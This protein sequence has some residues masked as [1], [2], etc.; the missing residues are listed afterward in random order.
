MNRRLVLVLAAFAAL[1]VFFP[2]GR[3]RP[4]SVPRNV[5]MIT[6]DTLRADRVGSY[7]SKAGLT[8]HLDAL[9]ADGVRFSTAYTPVPLTGPSHAT[10][11]TGRYPRTHGLL[12]NGTQVLPED[13]I[14]LSEVLH[15][16]GFQTGA[17]VSALVLASTFGLNQGWD[18]YYEEDIAGTT[19]R[20]GLWYDQRPG[21][22]TV[23]RA[24]TWLT[25]EG[26][27][28]F[29]LWVH[30]FDPHDPFEP[31]SPYKEKYA[32]APYDGEVAFTDAQVG[33]LLEQIKSMG[34][35]DNTLIVV[36]ADHGEGLGE[37][38]EEFHGIFLYN[39]TTHVPLIIRVPGGRRGAVVDDLASTLDI[40]PT[41][42]DALRIP[43]PDSKRGSAGIQGISLLPA[44][45]K[46]ARVPARSLF[47]ETIYPSASYGWAAPRALVRPSWKWIDLPEAELY[48]LSRDPAELKELHTSDPSRAS[49]LRAEYQA[50]KAD[51]DDSAGSAQTAAIDDE[52]RDRLISLG[53]I[54][55]EQSTTSTRVGLD[56][57]KVAFM[58]TPLRIAMTFQKNGKYA[59]A[60]FIYEKALEVDPDNRL[61]LMQMAQALSADG[62]LDAAVPYFEHAIAVYPDVEEF[63]RTYGL[64]CMNAGRVDQAQG[65]FK[66]ALAT[67][68]TSAHMHFLLGLARA[69]VKDW[70]GAAEELEL[71]TGL[72]RKMPRPHYL[73]A[74]CRLQIGDET[75]ALASLEEYLK[76]T[77]DVETALRDPRLA[78][79]W[80]K[81]VFQELLKRY[82]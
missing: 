20:H 35:Y 15:E 71:A 55:G 76:L 5:L 28:P 39:T 65:I 77:H 81:P 63:Y 44:V 45:M 27:R 37:H 60:V 58:T 42:L 79:A 69:Q 52:T 70:T 75:G 80:T 18:L 21:D 22:K 82:L 61:V 66:T 64:A 17:I 31:P 46:G 40:T 41:V 26:D 43:Q 49:D 50:M 8:P 33:R 78:A 38:K 56:P 12:N 36:A 3:L 53:Y 47:L 14:L 16:K 73:L 48:D 30:L 24:L 4:V 9:A 62:R 59:D 72:G 11:L 34:L 23:D 67:M 51:L 74:V 6:I 54:G 7:G 57:K 29:F 2:W 13:E 19:G 68:P 32:K 25:G 10:M 1:A